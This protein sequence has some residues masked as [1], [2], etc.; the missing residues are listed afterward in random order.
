MQDDGLWCTGPSQAESGGDLSGEL[1][2]PVEAS[3][4]LEP[5]PPLVSAA[6]WQ[7]SPEPHYP[8]RLTWHLSSGSPDIAALGSAGTT[9]EW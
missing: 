5:M 1:G 4:P 6:P 9:G 7:P 2:S 3:T 8:L